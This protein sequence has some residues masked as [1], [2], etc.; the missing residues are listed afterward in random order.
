MVTQGISS[1]PVYSPLTARP[2]D[3]HLCVADAEAASAIIELAT[4]AGKRLLRA[5]AHHLHSAGRIRSRFRRDA[6]VFTPS[7]TLRRSHHRRHAFAAEAGARQRAHGH[8]TV[9]G[10]NRG[11]HRAGRRPRARVRYRPRFHPTR[12]SRDHRPTLAVRPLQGDH[13]GRSHA[14]VINPEFRRVLTSR[15]ANGFLQGSVELTEWCGGVRFALPER[16]PVQDLIASRH[17]TYRHHDHPRPHHGWQPP[18]LPRAIRA[19]NRRRRR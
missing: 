16:V 14:A 1:R 13:R 17:L 3:L 10:R 11:S 5:C 18:Q 6:V 8:S 9:F 4:S 19:G 15:P 2:G 12:A 7:I